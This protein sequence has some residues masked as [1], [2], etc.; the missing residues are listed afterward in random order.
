M[1]VLYILKIIIIFFLLVFFNLTIV[2]LFLKKMYF[3]RKF[4]TD[5]ELDNYFFSFES[6]VN[7]LGI[8][9]FLQIISNKDKK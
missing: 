1:E 4:Q 3:I 9:K 5:E 7:K 6:L 8:K 2:Y